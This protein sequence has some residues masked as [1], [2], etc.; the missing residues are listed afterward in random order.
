M[1]AITIALAVVPLLSS[2]IVSIAL[3]VEFCYHLRY[4]NVR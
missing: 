2:S 3:N 1:I 4:F